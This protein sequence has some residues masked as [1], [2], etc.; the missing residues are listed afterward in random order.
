MGLLIFAVCLALWCLP[1]LRRWKAGGNAEAKEAVRALLLGLIPA[2]ALILLADNLGGLLLEMAGNGIA[3]LLGIELSFGTTLLYQFLLCFFVV[4]LAEESIKWAF[5][6]RCLRRKQ[7][8]T[9]LDAVVLA[10]AVGAGY[11]ITESVLYSL[12][13][14]GVLMGILRGAFVCHVMWQMFMGCRWFDSLEERKAGG[15]RKTAKTLRA[16]W[17]LPYLIHAANDFAL[18][19]AD[20]LLTDGAPF[21]Q[22]AAGVLL[23]AGVLALNTWNAVFC[24]RE[25][26]KN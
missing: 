6:R 4:A 1:V 17:F 10:G 8:L 9:R 2:S 20:V 19:A 14:G 15:D 16:G 26:K 13:G 12:R 21:A 18:E 25:T 22:T 23:F 7:D 3:R 24:I 5:A 11:E